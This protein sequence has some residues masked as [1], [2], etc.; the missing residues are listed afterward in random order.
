MRHDTI[1]DAILT[2]A[3]KPTWVSLI[4]RTETTTKSVKH[5][6]SRLM[7]LFPGLPGWAGA[8]KVKPI[9]ILLKQETVSGSGI[10]CAICMSA[11]RCRQIT[12][13]ATHHSV[14]TGQ[15][16]FLQAN[17]YHGHAAPVT[18]S[19]Q[20]RLGQLLTLA[21]GNVIVTRILVSFSSFSVSRW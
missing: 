8:R 18:R 19:A 14:F 16:L 11:P 1:R 4:C 12:M 9:W 21:L 6:H 10:S 2:C 7:A 20:S 15:V 17:W 3:R 13:P 5:T